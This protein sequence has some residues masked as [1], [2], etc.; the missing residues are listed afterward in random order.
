MQP[1]AGC[2][3]GRWGQHGLEGTEALV[4]IKEGALGVGVVKATLCH[5]SHLVQREVPELGAQEGMLLGATRHHISQGQTVLHQGRSIEAQAQ[6]SPKKCQY[7]S[8]W[9]KVT[10]LEAQRHLRSLCRVPPRAARAWRLTL[11]GDWSNKGAN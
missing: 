7:Y 11:V 5:Q 6:E 4:Q 9:G 8:L 3:G 10:K 2:L 1:G